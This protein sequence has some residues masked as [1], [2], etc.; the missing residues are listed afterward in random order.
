LFSR[1]AV[2]SKD[3]A[4]S[5]DFRE[6]AAEIEIGSDSESAAPTKMFLYNHDTLFVHPALNFVHLVQMQP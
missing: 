6:F 3:G 4:H 1:G 2:N 5:R